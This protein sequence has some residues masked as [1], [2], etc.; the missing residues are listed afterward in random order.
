MKKRKILFFLMSAVGGAER[1]TVTFAKQLDRTQYDV[2]FIILDYYNDRHIE[3]FIPKEYRI[4]HLPCSFGISLK[5]IWA[6]YKVLKKERPDIVFSS[7][8]SINLRLLLLA[9]FFKSIKFL[10]RNN[11][12]LWS[13]SVSRM[14]K[15]AMQKVYSFAKAIIVQTEEMKKELS[16]ALHID[17]S[18]I[19]II[20][21]PIDTETIQKKLLDYVDF[22]DGSKTNY[23][24]VCRFVKGK[25]LDVLVKAF[26]IVCK[27]FPDSVLYIV[28]KYE[29]AS[30]YYQNIISLIDD[31]NLT[32]KIHLVGFTDNPYK[33]MRNASCFVLSSR[34]EGLPNAL[35]EAQYI[36][37]PAAAC[38]CIP[39]I[40][41]IVDE[42]KTGYLAEVEDYKGL[43]EAM[44]KA[45][46]LGRIKTT[47]KSSSFDDFLNVLN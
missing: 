44:M 47:Y 17:D 21:N 28:G 29:E 5:V 43:A 30:N 12:N 6:F 35:I 2:C 37:T 42:G 10:V 19:I 24:S 3:D 8:I 26:D 11:I 27:K 38:T 1:M 18:K 9:P 45:S 33:Y 22:M 15:F 13:P 40:G 20:H 36:G 7:L 14:Q 34:S 16:E 23:V 31:L 4:I 32:N 46:K 41:R 25:G 39:I